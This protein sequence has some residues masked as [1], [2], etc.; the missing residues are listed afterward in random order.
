MRSIPA[1]VVLGL[2]FSIP[3]FADST[4]RPEAP[5]DEIVV[6]ATRTEIARDR[7][8]APVIVIGR[9]EIERSLALDIAELLRFHAGLDVARSGG[10]GQ[11]T[12]LFIRGADSNHTLVLMDGVEI[13]PGTLGGAAL[14]NISPDIV[15][16]IEIV[17]G[18]RSSLYG[19]EAIGGVVNIITREAPAGRALTG[20]AGGGR[21]DTREA[22]FTT[23][24]NVD[25]AS[26]DLS[27]AWLT[28]D[29]YPTL[30]ANDVDR[31]Y[32]HLSL[33]LDAGVSVG[34]FAASLRHWQAEG[35]NEYSDF[36]GAPVDQDYANR[37]TAIELAGQATE[38]WSPRLN[39]SR[40]VDDIEQ[41]QSMD[42]VTT[43]RDTLDWQNDLTLGDVQLI[44][45]GL[46]VSREETAAVFFG[47]PLEER[48][49]EGHVA[50]DVRALFIEDHIEVGRHGV[51]LAARYTDHETFGA[52]TTWNAEYGLEL[53]ADT[54]LTFGTG[55]GFRA[56][57]S[58]DRFGFGGNPDLEPERSRNFE[59]G[60]RHSLD[61]HQRLTLNL[62]HNE[63]DDLIEFVTLSADPF[64]GENRNIE[65]ARIRGV[66]AGY[67][68][69]GDPWRLRVAA[70]VQDAQN[71]TEDTRLIRRAR[72]SLTFSVGRA[73]GSHELGL[74][75]LA[76]GDREDFGLPM[77]V[78]LGG[79]VL[80]NL[81]GRFALGEQWGLRA[82]VENL[83]DADYETVS[84]FNSAS[85]GVYIILEVDL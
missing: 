2:T 35:T 71:L 80:A 27:A 17:K 54:R 59:V 3:C 69:R 8:L 56:P 9:E 36:L 7:S 47:T 77:S 25:N 83:L 30:R 55:T 64:I 12:S 41:N 72:R 1:G 24:M 5:F 4:S 13:N 68:L 50:T 38:I 20:N 73:F 21:Y 48:A 15:E 85:R 43:R 82:K 44:V 65:Q 58:V 81:T 67:E 79:Y 22:S 10:P 6:T 32:D 34:R 45:A 28:T 76:T 31:G 74:D 46:Y 84:G 11:A 29:G 70:T 19:S 49:G 14:Q 63:I 51:V 23:G 52:E 66:E 26:L 39:L 78:E 61:A 16:R 60:L 40:A 57:D 18:P 75:M 42:F 62:F 33:N 37:A 53:D